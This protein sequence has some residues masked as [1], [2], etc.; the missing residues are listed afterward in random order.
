MRM[1]GLARAGFA[2]MR[3]RPGFRRDGDKAHLPMRHATFG[4]DAIGEDPHGFCGTAKHRNF[5]TILVIDM[6]MHGRDV[7]LMVIVMRAGQSL[8]KVSGVVVEHIR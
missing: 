4:N 2:A 5:E 1:M 6:H 3:V 7:K 8:R